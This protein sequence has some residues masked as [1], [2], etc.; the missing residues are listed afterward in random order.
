MNSKWWL[1]SSLAVTTPK[2]MKITTSDSDAMVFTPY[3][4]VVKLFFEMFKKAYLFCAIPQ[5]IKAI[6]PDQCKHSD[7]TKLKYAEKDQNV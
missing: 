7:K 2:N 6:I 4:T 1:R 5:P 3:L